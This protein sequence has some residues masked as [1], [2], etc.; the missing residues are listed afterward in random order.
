MVQ[1]RD[2][3][4]ISQIKSDKELAK[5]VKTFSNLIK[6][7]DDVTIKF[8]EGSDCL[9]CHLLLRK[10]A[11]FLFIKYYKIVLD[12]RWNEELAKDLWEAKIV[13]TD[14]EQ[15]ELAH[16][17]GKVFEKI[18]DRE[19]VVIRDYKRKGKRDC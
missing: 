14:K 8:N 12:I 11:K 13:V 4:R 3:S 2:S 19:V 10:P 17:V 6:V 5:K 16:E 9:S 7:D 1:D 15:C 18:F